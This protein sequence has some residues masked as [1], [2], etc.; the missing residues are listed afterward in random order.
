MSKNKPSVA[1]LK[2]KYTPHMPNKFV[3]NLA[4]GLIGPALKLVVNYKIKNKSIKG[5]KGPVVV[6]A[7]HCSMMDWLYVPLAM[8]PRKLSV[9]VS[10]YFFAQPFLNSL[11]TIIGAIPK[12]Q[13]CSDV[14]AVKNMLGIAKQG[15]NI[16]LFPEGRMSCAGGSEFF[17][18]STVKLMQHIGYPVI[19]VHLSG[20]HMTMPKWSSKI[21]RG[22]IDVVAEPLFTP[23]DLKNLSEEE[24]FEKMVERLTTDDHAWQKENHVRFKGGDDAE[25]LDGVCY[26]CP[27]CGS[28]TDMRTKGNKIYCE[29]CGNGATL[30]EYYQLTPLDDSCVIP[31]NTAKWL[32]LER[33]LEEKRA[34]DEDYSLSFK[35]DYHLT[36]AGKKWFTPAGSG[37]F[38]ISKEGFLYKGSYFGEEYELLF[39]LKALPT[40]AHG[41]N[42]SL[43]LH[44]DSVV[45]RFIP[46]DPQ[47]TQRCMLAIEHLHNHYYGKNDI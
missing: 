39:P 9:V 30:D 13:F 8:R 33:D 5:I 12:D 38:T 16:A 21:R 2:R 35:C 11:L 45:H 29:K 41:P 43:E 44:R 6:L 24:L 17:S 36:S 37:V 14:R 26:Y 46:E 19:S 25:G 31:E 28:E 15:G 47:V 20:A 10:N 7:N 3:Y 32:D 42:A 34:M 4:V 1:E 40:C 22:R 18:R 23:E 27:K